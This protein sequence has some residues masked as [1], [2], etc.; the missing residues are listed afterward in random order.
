M[1]T[2]SLVWDLPV[3][4]LH[5]ALAA[6]LTGALV[7][8]FAVDDDSPLFAYHIL[9]GM[10]AAGALLLRIVWGLIGPSPANFFR[11]PLGVQALAKHAAGL[12]QPAE[13]EPQAGHNPAASWVMLVMLLLTAATVAS[14]WFDADDLHEGFAVAVASFIGL[15]LA[16]LLLHRLR[17]RENLALTM[18]H[19]R[20]LAPAGSAAVRPALAMGVLFALTLGAWAGALWRGYDSNAGQ[21]RLPLGLPILQMS[22]DH[23][24]E[25]SE[26]RRS[27]RDHH[28]G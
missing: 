6:G 13:P 14:G 12:L 1:Q 7:I 10:F 21:L 8:G 9:A 18:V 25:K 17:H 5:W 24:S 19:G 2:R 27:H 26:H 28:D 23:R 16:G 22:E 15:H 11:W 4:V 20:K 3:R